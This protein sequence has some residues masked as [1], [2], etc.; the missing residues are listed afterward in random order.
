MK[1]KIGN[2]VYDVLVAESEEEKA[3]GLQDVEEMD[4]NEGMLFIYDEPE[5]LD[6]WMVDTS[7]PLDIVFIDEDLIVKSV[8]SGQPNSE[9]Y[10]SETN[11]QYVLE[12]NKNSGIKAGDEVELSEEVEI[13]KMYV[14]GIDGKPQME[15]FGGERIFS[16]KNTK[17]LVN[18]SKRAYLSKKDSDY[19]RLG[20]QVFKYLGIQDGNDPDYVELKKEG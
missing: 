20:K 2:K 8:K 18:M 17:I 15:L 7:I 4:D 19:K 14:I 16:R 9:E 10:I 13:N 6:F 5:D 11:V 12:V 1:I 3:K